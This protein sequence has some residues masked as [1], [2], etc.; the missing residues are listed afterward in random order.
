M[1]K[2]PGLALLLLA[3]WRLPPANLAK[4]ANQP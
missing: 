2:Y 1:K 4:W 3:L